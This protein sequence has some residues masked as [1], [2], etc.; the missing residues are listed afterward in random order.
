[1]IQY[2]RYQIPMMA[3]LSPQAAKIR[4]ENAADDDTGSGAA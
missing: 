1:M 3:R 4:W 2:L